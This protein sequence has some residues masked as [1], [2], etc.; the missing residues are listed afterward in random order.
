MDKRFWLWATMAMLAGCQRPDDPSFYDTQWYLAPETVQ[1]PLRTA[2]S[3]TKGVTLRLTSDGK[4]SGSSGCNR[5]FGSYQLVN[6]TAFQV[7]AIGSTK[8]AC[9]GE[10]MQGEG[11]FLDRLSKANWLEQE[12]DTLKLYSDGFETPLRFRQQR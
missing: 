10:L 3:G 7:G 11:L 8:M 2:A 4:L 12:G 9:L 6:G 5:Y 1:G